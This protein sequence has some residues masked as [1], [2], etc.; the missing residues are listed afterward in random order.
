MAA[1]TPI[2][3]DVSDHRATV[4]V[5]RVRGDGT[6]L[7]ESI[8]DCWATQQRIQHARDLPI[9]ENMTYVDKP[10]FARSE[11]QAFRALRQWVEGLYEAARNGATAPRGA[12]VK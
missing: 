4:W 8:R 9:W 11:A 5:P 12:L 7:D 10:P 3:T 6:P 1:T 2:T